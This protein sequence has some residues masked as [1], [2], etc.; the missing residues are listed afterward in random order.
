MKKWEVIWESDT[1]QVG[2]WDNCVTTVE[3]DNDNDVKITI[4]YVKWRNNS[5]SLAER[6]T[7]L[8]EPI[9]Q[10]LVQKIKDYDDDAASEEDV[11]RAIEYYTEVQ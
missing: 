4:P 10:Q 9:A 5:G 11:M 6:K 2:I 3:K 1:Y 8:S 7:Y